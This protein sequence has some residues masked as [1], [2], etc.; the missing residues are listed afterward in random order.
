MECAPNCLQGK[1]ALITGGGTGIGKA[2]ALAYAKAGASVC[3][4]GRRLE[5]LDEVR[6]RVEALGA[7][8][9][10]VAG[11]VSNLDDCR[12]MVKE[13]V[14]TFGRLDLLVNNAGVYKYEKLAGMA[15]DELERILAI[16][17]RGPALLT[18]AA[19]SALTNAGAAHG[20]ALVLNIS[21]SA[22]LKPISGLSIYAGAK[23][24]LNYMTQT[25]ARELAGSQIRVNAIC[26]G[27]VDTP[28]HTEGKAPEEVKKTY[29]MFAPMHPLGR[30]GQAEEI[31]AL[32]LFVASPAAA[33]MTGALL[34]MDGGLSLL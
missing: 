33:W 26:P 30:I 19:L 21:S 13:V 20:D 4:T 18:Q 16:N 9:L 14:D 17:V 2:I 8:C 12:T 7:Q 11:D 5:K 23:A 3:I 29:E 6:A 10:R 24:M 25:W 32:A 1:A 27:V 34:T 31:A 28:I 22:S 15:P